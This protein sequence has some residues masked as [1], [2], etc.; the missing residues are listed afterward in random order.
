MQK[1]KQGKVFWIFGNSGAG[2]TTLAHQ[3]QPELDAIILDGDELRTVWTLGLEKG[4][5][6]EQNRRA[7]KL[8]SLIAK[9]GQNVIIATI[10]PYE[11]LRREAEK[12]C[13]PVWIYLPGGHAAT[14]TYPFEKPSKVD[15]QLDPIPN[16]TNASKILR[17]YTHQPTKIGK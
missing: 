9:Q 7:A 15:I 17:A 1:N 14:D 6:E 12:F 13:D 3:I 2:K 5:R 11:T 8:A 10:C 4:A 16:E